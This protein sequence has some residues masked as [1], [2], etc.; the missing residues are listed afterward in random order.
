MDLVVAWIAFPLLLAVV[1]AGLGLLAERLAG[2]RLPGALVVPLGFAGLVVVTTLTTAWTVTAP[3]TTIVVVALAA[4]GFAAGARRLRGTRVEPS[5]VLLAVGVLAVFA[6]PVVLA[7]DA[8]FAGYGVLGDTAIQLIGIDRL[9]GAGHTVAGLAPSSY[10][11]ALDAYFRSGY[12]FGA[13]LAVGVLRPL[14]GQDAAWLYQP[15]LAFVAVCLGLALH[16]IACSLLPSRRRL[17]AVVAFVAAQ[18]ALVYAYALQGSIKELAAAALVAL[19]VALTI[20]LAQ[21]VRS[22]PAALRAGLPLAVATAASLAVLGLAAAVW[23]G[24]IL[25]ASLVA[26][27]GGRRPSRRT[28]AQVGLFAV[29]ALVLAAPT[30]ALLRGYFDVTAGTVTAKAEVGNLIGALNPLQTVGIWIN[31]DYRLQPGGHWLPIT[32]ALLVLAGI[33]ALAG[34]VSAVRR[35]A[36]PPLLYAGVALLG[37]LVVARAGSPWA[38]AKAFMIGSPAVLL[39]ALL[40]PA[41]LLSARRSRAQS[42]VARLARSLAAGLL[43]AVAG[44]VLLSNAFA[45]RDVSLAPRD[46]LTELGGVGER[47][48]G[49]GPLLATEFEEFGKHFLRATDPSGVSEAYSP[50]PADPA[51]P[52]RP[53]PRFGYP[54]DL[55]E[56]SQAYVQSY[57]LLLLRRSPVAS[58]PPADYV[59]VWRGTW[60]E[61]WERRTGG[62]RVLAH[63]SLGED[64]RSPSAVPRCADIATLARQ[65]RDAGARLAYV[66]RPLPPAFLPATARDRPASWAVDAREPLVLRVSGGGRVDGEIAVGRAGA[67]DSWIGGSFGSAPIQISIDGRAAGSVSRQLDGRGQYERAGGP[68]PLSVGTH[69]VEVTRGSR[70]LA[71]G[72]GS[73]RIGPVVLAPATAAPSAVRLIPPRAWHSLCGR[74]LDWVEIVRGW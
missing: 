41:T 43:V 40:G 60:Y 59:R 11:A 53:G 48:A 1:C 63:L 23:A 10:Q 70:T 66:K 21:A 49:Q 38:E 6:A 67:Y 17:A 46:R 4:A 51:P 39:L 56:L 52:G 44:G 45:Y 68:I 15:G 54:S 19:L 72:G 2:T 55:D 3:A 47:F 31:G 7:G 5:L 24:P 14:T 58:R 22:A 26:L 13:Q 8:T 65:A 37:C 62:P 50:R 71:P 34:A 64:G 16:P 32:R 29:V 57:P 73:S 30:V 12:P 18:P 28:A 35:R 36:W 9:L 61:V 74:A 25:L 27:V 42:A 69:R 33:G 20:A